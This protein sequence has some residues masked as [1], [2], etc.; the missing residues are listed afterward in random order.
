M[1]ALKEIG[2]IGISDGRTGGC[3]YLLRPSFGAMVRLGEPE[4]IVNLFAL[5]HGSEAQQFLEACGGVFHHIPAW[6]SPTLNAMSSRLLSAAVRVVQACCDDDLSAITGEW[7]GWKR[8]V[9]YR[10][11]LMPRED[12]VIIARQLLLHGIIGQAK[13]RRLQRHESSNTTNEFRA[14]D[15]ISAARSHFGMSRDEAARLTMTEFQFLLAAK[16]PDQKGFTREEYDAVADDYLARKAK[17]LS[18]DR[19]NSTV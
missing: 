14:F 1:T 19:G 5:I 17:K 3:D 12:I 2:E 18:T 9:V 10:P 16:Y 4:E 11:G 13:V 6:V 15:Y 8:Y 7:K